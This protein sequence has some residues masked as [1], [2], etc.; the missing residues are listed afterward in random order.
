MKRKENEFNFTFNGQ[1]DSIEV[2]SLTGSLI[3]LNS[4]LQNISQEIG[5]N[6]K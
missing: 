4:L 6:K 1:L 2:N 5:T 3:S